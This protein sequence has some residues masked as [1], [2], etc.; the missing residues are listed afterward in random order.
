[1]SPLDETGSASGDETLELTGLVRLAVERGSLAKRDAVVVTRESLMRGV[2]VQDVIVEHALI[3]PHEIDVLERLL[4]PRSLVPGYEIVDVLG[5]GAMGVVFKARQLALDRLVAL[6]TIRISR[7]EDTA[8]VR[9]AKAEALIVAGLS[10]PNVATAYDQGVHEGRLFLAMELVD[11]ETWMDVIR[12]GV[13]GEERVVWSIARQVAAGLAHAAAKGVVHRDVKPANVLL[14]DAPAGS[15]LPPG[16]PLAK[17]TDFG[18]ALGPNRDD[19]TRL[20][21]AGTGLGTPDYVA[22]EQLVDSDVDSRADVYALGASVCHAL[23]AENL[24][25][26]ST[27]MQVM[28][29]KMVGDES[30]RTLP[31]HVSPASRRLLERMT[32]HDPSRRIGDYRTLL[33]EIDGVL[34]ECDPDARAS[35]RDSRASRPASSRSHPGRRMLLGGLS[36]LIAIGVAA[37]V[38]TRPPSVPDRRVEIER[39]GPIRYLFD[40]ESTPLG[41]QRGRWEPTSDDLGGRRLSGTDGWL[42][43]ALTHTDGDPPGLGEVRF[44]CDQG[45]A[46]VVEVHL[47]TD[48]PEEGPRPVLRL[49]ADSLELGWR[50]SIDGEFEPSRT[51]PL[52]EALTGEEDAYRNVRVF[53]QP[54]ALFVDVDGE[55]QAAIHIRVGVGTPETVVLRVLGGTAHFESVSTANFE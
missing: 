40:G 55:Q 10:H 11:G 36:A 5:Q 29:A 37:F 6:K 38:L 48:D 45:T 9:R 39:V 17:I 12:R 46:E 3:D 52:T 15:D 16:V 1:M 30:W 23:K 19:G 24:F 20:T 33:E 2:S 41:P 47:T 32:A 49:L 53:W 4:E 43:L 26:S 18:I 28:R 50:P 7:V 25:G 8:I 51:A 31:N 27:A 34:A 14:T 44:G 13:P 35:H 21:M 22:P 42:G 54:G